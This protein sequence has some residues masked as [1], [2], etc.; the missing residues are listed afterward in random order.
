MTTY[1]N[2]KGLSYSMWGDGNDEPV[3]NQ[4]GCEVEELYYDEDRGNL[5]LTFIDSCHPDTWVRSL[6]NGGYIKIDRVEDERDTTRLHAID[7]P[8]K[9]RDEWNSFV[10]SLPKATIPDQ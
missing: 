5:V 8:I 6:S 7:I 2:V 3:L 4:E 1:S 9:P 10:D